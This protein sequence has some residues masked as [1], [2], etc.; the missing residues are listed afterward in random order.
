MPKPA[1]VGGK[2]FRFD[3]PGDV[4]NGPEADSRR[5]AV[6]ETPGLIAQIL[7][8]IQAD[9]TDRRR[10]VRHEAAG[11]K[12]WVG[13]WTGDEFGGVRGRVRDISRGGAQVVLGLKPPKRAAIWLY[14]E[15]DETLAYVRGDVVGH[16]PSPGA[17]YSVR[18]R[19]V[20]PCPTILLQAVVC[21]PASAARRVREY[22]RPSLN[23]PEP[24][25][26][27]TG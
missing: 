7:Q 12:V 27:S 13:W 16:T 14:K 11:R 1:S 3:R 10:G 26:G 23:E 9:P 18:F 4:G 17:R 21:E 15:V 8:T 20:A 22:S 2:S 25:P 24:G 6:A 19:F 5:E